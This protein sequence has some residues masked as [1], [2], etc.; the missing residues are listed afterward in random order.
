[1]GSSYF[2]LRDLNA[3]GE[4]D[5]LISNGDNWDYSSVPKPYHGF[6]VYENKGNG[7]F[8]EAWFYPQYGA[9]K[10]MAVDFDQD[11]DLDFATIAFYDE[12]QHPEQQFL[13][14]E[15]TGN[16]TFKPR[17]IP[18]AALGK[19]LTMDVGDIDGDGDKDIVLGAYAHNVME[20]SKLLL[21]GIDEVPNV[22]IIENKKS[23]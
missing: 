4:L 21:R 18:E 11:G 15:N 17:F 9:A 13:L 16:M 10:A 22:L 14:F 19:W 23:Q 7:I 2:E 3:D 6:R 1:M 20:Y 8:E 12:L 5:L